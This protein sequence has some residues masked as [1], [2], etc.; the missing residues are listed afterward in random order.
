MVIF[1]IHIN[2]SIYNNIIIN[3]MQT[4]LEGEKVTITIIDQYSN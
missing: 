2:L 1:E 3:S 4:E